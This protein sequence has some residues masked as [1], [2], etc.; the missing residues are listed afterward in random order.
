M[1][2]RLMLDYEGDVGVSEDGGIFYSFPA[3]RKTADETP[4]REPPPAW[5]RARPLPPLTGNSVGAN[6]LIG[7]IN[8]F[9]LLMGGWAVEH[10][11]TI[12]RVVHLFDRVPYHVEGTG[13][14]IALGLVP[15]VFSAFLFL[16]PLA[17]AVARPARV[18][19]AE[20]EKGRLGVLREVLEGVKARRPV[21][22]ATAA[23]AWQNAAGK[24]PDGK[25]LDRE[26]VAL[27][28]D[29]A[30]EDSG[31]TRWRFPDLETEAAA[32]EA[33][34]EAAAEEEARLGEIV[35]ATDGPASRH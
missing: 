13:M 9:N 18:R 10:G 14:P 27:G 11:M 8:L 6:V 29:V 24:A 7:A 26:L 19:A 2:A 31:A 4:E 34:R 5:S 23:Q 25:K 32:V 20:D 28:G 12:E 3:L 22:D 1:M 35:Y 15:L 21:T 16:V 30:I 17:R 33:E